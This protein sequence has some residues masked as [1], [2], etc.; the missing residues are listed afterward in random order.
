MK[1]VVFKIRA[2]E[3]VLRAGV[4]ERYADIA[5]DRGFVLLHAQLRGAL[6]ENN[7]D[8]KRKSNISFFYGAHLMSHIPH[9]RTLFSLTG[10][11]LPT[12]TKSWSFR[13]PTVLLCSG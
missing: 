7:L 3:R 4:R 1:L 13:P 5:D 2:E 8:R 11:L 10:L 6:L 9:K 12:K